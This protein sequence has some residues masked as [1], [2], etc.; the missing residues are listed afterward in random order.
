VK[1][2]KTLLLFLSAACAI[3]AAA[4][5]RSKSLP[6][7]VIDYPAD[8]TIFPPDLAAPTFLWRDSAAAATGWRIAVEFA[9]GAAPLQVKSQGQYMQVGE[10]DPSCVGA[11]PPKLTPEQAAAH[12]W[13]PDSKTWAAIKTGAANGA[14][15]VTISGFADHP[16][17]G[18]VS[19]GRI[20]I[21]TSRDAVGAPIF[22]RDVPLI[23]SPTVNGVIQPLPPFAIGLIAWRLRNVGESES[24]TVMQGLPTCANCHSFSL[25]GKT[26]GLDVDGPQ[27]D[28]GLYALVPVR[29]DMSIR[30]EDVIRWSSFRGAA[31]VKAGE[32]SAKRFGFMS[33]VS[34]DGR[35]VVT[36]IDD[37]RT[38]GTQQFNGLARGLADRFYN[39][40]YKDYA[41]G[42]V[43]YPTRGILAWYDRAAGQL[44]PL[45]GADDPRYVQTN[46][47]WSP[48]GK[49][50][51]FA[52]ADAR[53]PYSPGQKA[54]EY[55]NSPDETQI[56]YDLYRIPFNGGLGGQAQRIAGASRNGMSNNFAKVSPDGKW[57]VFVECRNG[58]LMRPD[59]R[60]FIV[61]AAGGAA[62]LL[63]AN[64]RLMNS[65]HSFSPNGRWLVFSSKARS[66]YTQMYLTH[67]DEDGNDSPA[68][69]IEN[70]TAANRAVNI[71]E[72]VN[73]A[74]EGIARIDAPATEFYRLFD[75]ASELG[76]KSD[77]EAAIAKWNEALAI[78]PGDAKAHGNLG[79]L[80]TTVGRTDEAM[81]HYRKAIEYEPDYPD[82]YTNVG[83][84]L[85]RAGSLDDAMPYLE[86]AAQLSPW[87]AKV[88]SNLGAALAESGRTGDAI[89]ECQKALQLSPDDSEAH[90]NLA[91]ALAKA[92][93]SDEA[94]ANFEQAV[95]A[96]P[97]SS[98]LRFYLGRLLA[99]LGRFDQAIPQLEK[100]D[101][102]HDPAIGGMLAAVYAQVGRLND[103]LET[104]RTALRLARQR[105][106]QELAQALSASVASYETALH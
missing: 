101:A 45:P 30:N 9:G 4:G 51:V 56:Q 76:R 77:Y 97:G 50:L 86:K 85:A 48:D 79:V 87:D 41:F 53:N 35:N 103:A 44:Q 21:A 73:I 54:S 60:L 57:I 2:F 7:I 59:S 47:V 37:P 14:A 78:S 74:P 106:L 72:F 18:A 58:L 80:L 27:N 105:N 20:S 98:E 39:A 104:A 13:K 24:K 62:R 12:T 83:I 36:T 49:Y 34:P 40:G 65:W 42:Q 91:I 99:S 15:M 71:P 26:L 1:G 75:V 88:H 100:A 92:G 5:P 46:A 66:P 68:I 94:I 93:R 11:V 3:P 38:R 96:N 32:P 61:P 81:Q 17:A 95:A 82:G 31:P 8:G 16:G 19:S 67:L 28:K 43:F 22:Y 10:S 70:A 23:P 52:R 6:L 29:R 33:Q 90:A 55:A 69:L 25:D 89:A 102:A 84:A 63:K 64:T